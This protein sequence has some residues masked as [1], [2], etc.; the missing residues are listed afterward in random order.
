MELFS[1]GVWQRRFWFVV[2]PQN[3]LSYGM[4]PASEKAAF[5][6]RRPALHA[7]NA[8]DI[9]S[10]VAEMGNQS[11]SRTIIAHRSDGQDSRA[12]RREVV[13]SVGAAARHNLSF[14]MFE[15]Q[16]RRLARDTRDLAILEFIGHEMSD[17]NDRFR[18]ELLDALAESKKV[19]G[20]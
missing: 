1:N 20:R 8:G 2:D 7:E 6:W 10:L 15:D 17:G 18:G 19:D 5:G 13:A 14:A 16:D 4:R 9:D 11:V 12:E 3:L